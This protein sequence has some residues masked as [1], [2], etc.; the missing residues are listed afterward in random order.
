[1]GRPAKDSKALNLRL[2]SKVC[3]R[4]EEYCQETGITKTTAVERILTAYFDV[5]DE[6]IK[7]TGERKLL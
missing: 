4:L 1:M 2:D 7:K 3:D 6:K 5:R